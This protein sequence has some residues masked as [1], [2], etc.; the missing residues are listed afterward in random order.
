MIIISPGYQSNENI[1]PVDYHL[2]FIDGLAGSL[3][4]ADSVRLARVIRES[5]SFNNEC[6]C[7]ITTLGSQTLAPLGK[8]SETLALEIL[9][10]LFDAL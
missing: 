4:V 2:H 9:T 6:H 7:R 1:S 10:R 5:L 3:A 8:L